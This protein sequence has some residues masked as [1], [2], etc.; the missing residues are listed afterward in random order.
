[1]RADLAKAIID[2]GITCIRLGGD[3]SGSPGFKWKTM[4]GDPDRRPQYNSCWYPF[5]TRG[6]S[7][8]EF[9]EF[10]RAA[11][12]EPIPCLNPDESPADVAE[13]VRLYKLKYVQ[14]GNG[15]A[16][17]ARTAAVADAIHAV[18]PER[19]AARRLDRARGAGPARRASGC[20]Q[21]KETLGGKLYAP[22]IFPYNSEVTGPAQ[23]QT[24]LDRLAPLRGAMKLYVQEVNGGN[25]DLLRGLADAGFHNVT[26]QNADFVD[27]VTY[28]GMVE[29]DRTA[30]DNGWDQGRIFFDNH[31]AWLQP[32]GWALRL[33]REHYQPLAVRD[34]HDMSE[35]DLRQPDQLRRA[36]RSTCWSPAPPGATTAACLCLKVVNFAPFSIKAKVHVAGMGA[37]APTAK[38]A[39]LTAANLKLDNTAEEPTRVAPT[40]GSRDGIGPDFVHA[41]PAYSYT[42][43][44]M[45]A[46]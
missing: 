21:L 16:G 5:E 29:A 45:R 24:M 11:G 46:K 22:A 27:I 36:R 26:E 23:F 8:V 3:F 32:H 34:D 7:I 40:A 43:I 25:H 1:M 12:I 39:L 28:C 2:S 44:D 30:Q 18:D 37:L 17:D 6:W 9:I 41:F 35:D 14:L 31:R 4:T 15:Y 33:A 10:C 20:A 42:V 38:T 19:E 13:L